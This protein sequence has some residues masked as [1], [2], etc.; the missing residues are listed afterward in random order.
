MAVDGSVS[1]TYKTQ[2]ATSHH[3]QIATDVIMAKRMA[4]V[5]V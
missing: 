3:W 1:V 5:Q 4:K 2:L